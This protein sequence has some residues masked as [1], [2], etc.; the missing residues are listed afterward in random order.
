MTSLLTSFREN[1]LDSGNFVVLGGTRFFST[2]LNSS[3]VPATPITSG[4]TGFTTAYT[5][6][7]TVGA[8][9]RDMGKTIVVPAS[10][11]GT[12]VGA[13]AT[14][15]RKVQWVNPASPITNGVTGP[16]D[17]STGTAPGYHTFYIRLQTNGVANTDGV[18]LKVARTM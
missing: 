1:S 2:T 11:A 13:G 16:A 10:G 18:D 12:S 8:V 4:T 7:T 14:L 3:N 5:A 9:L 6:I 15:Y 17:S